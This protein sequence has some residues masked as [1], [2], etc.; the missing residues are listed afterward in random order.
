MLENCSELI[1]GQVNGL[2]PLVILLYPFL[3][4]P[5]DLFPSFSSFF[6]EVLVIS[7]WTAAIG[8]HRSERRI[9]PSMNSPAPNVRKLI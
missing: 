7:S 6:F 1:G 4:E 5:F 2:S 8:Y 9:L 3:F